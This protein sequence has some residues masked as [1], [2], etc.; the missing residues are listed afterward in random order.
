MLE[1]F[2]YAIF[3]DTNSYIMTNLLCGDVEIT[4]RH[5]VQCYVT[6]KCCGLSHL[7]SLRHSK[8]DIDLI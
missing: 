6:E 8:V 1:S 2:E 3:L 5:I 7:F 4:L